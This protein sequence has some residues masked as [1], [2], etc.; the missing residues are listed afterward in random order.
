[1]ISFHFSNV[2][3]PTLH[4][5]AHYL[6][7]N[8]AHE[9]DPV[10]ADFLDEHLNYPELEHLEFKHLLQAFLAPSLSWLQPLTFAIDDANWPEVL[11]H[12]AKINKVHPWILKP[13]LLNNG[14]HIHIFK[15][16]EDVKRHYLQ[17][18]RLGGPHVL[19]A[20]IS[21][22]HL[23]KGPE[24]GHKYSLRMFM[25]MS[26]SSAYLYPHGY[27]NIALKPY[28]PNQFHDLRTHLTNE[29]L[30]HDTYNVIQ[31]PTFRYA[32]FQQFWPQI[33]SMSSMLAK[34]FLS[35]FGGNHLPKLG[36]LGID[37]M[38]DAFERVWLLEVN[39]G[40]CFPI[41]HDHPLYHSLYHPFWQSV[42]SEIV[43]PKFA[44]YPP[45]FKQFIL[46]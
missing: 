21:E 27:F 12:I 32:L 6:E 13:A 4:Q 36:F 24:R 45:H 20:Y 35:Q 9:Q 39:H 5:L 25:I 28:E 22:P 34:Q 38:V 8:G 19:Q 16:L 42:V 26:E 23:L 40:P 18:K 44:G 37:F 43:I 2:N 41:S 30:E 7:Q 14:Q 11:E 29:H 1:M 46:V 17:S 33:Q 15:S 3:T 10:S 31:I